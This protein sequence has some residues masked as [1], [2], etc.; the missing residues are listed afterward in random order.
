MVLF[1]SLTHF[2]SRHIFYHCQRVVT[3][4]SCPGTHIPVTRATPTKTLKLGMSIRT[5]GLPLN[6]IL[7]CKRELRL[8]MDS[9][10]SLFLYISLI[11]GI[12]DS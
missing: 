9:S 10:L 12:H 4:Q 8:N 7:L 1:F 2:S 3:S 6:A 11:Y 5:H